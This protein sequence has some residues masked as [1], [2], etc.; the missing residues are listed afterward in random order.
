MA[1]NPLRVAV[2]VKNTPAS[3]ERDR[4]N[5]GMWSYPVDEFT[6]DFFAL[7]KAFRLD[8]AHLKALGY[9]LVFHEDGGSWGDY[10][11]AALPVIYYSIDS[12]LSLEHH[13][14][15][16]KQQAERADLVLV[17]HDRLERF[18]AGTRA[19]VRRLS[20][21]VNDRLFYERSK[22]IDVAFHCGGGDMG[23]TLMRS[24]LE[25]VCT[26]ARL[27]YVSGAV[28]LAT[29]AQHMGEA[30]VVVNIPRNPSNRPHRVFDAQA[31]FAAL[32][33]TPLPDVSD[34]RRRPFDVLTCEFLDVAERARILVENGT[35]ELLAI[36]GRETVMQYHTWQVR[37]RELRALVAEQFAI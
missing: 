24:Q 16:R 27:R 3:F 28:D 33:T 4:R 26:R 18:Q 25:A 6:W 19:P 11:G 36:A 35:W 30:R 20:F 37:A 22:T 10:A 9:D 15:P 17:D 1:L 34:E 12:T 31:S 14:I 7:G 29:Y 5:M 13:F 8:T 32:V 23:R 21:C 2:I